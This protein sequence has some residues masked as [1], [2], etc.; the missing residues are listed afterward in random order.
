MAQFQETSS[1]FQWDSH[2]PLPVTWRTVIESAISKWSEMDTT[3]DNIS[4]KE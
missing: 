3:Q 1:L 2:F 4:L